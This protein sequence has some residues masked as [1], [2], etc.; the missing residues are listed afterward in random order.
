MNE[1]D[2]LLQKIS[3]YS[4]A[5]KEWN[6]YLDTHPTDREGL[7]MHKRMADKAKELIAKYEEKYG[8]LTTMSSADENCFD[9]IAEPW[10][11]DNQ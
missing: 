11:W 5:E 3:A 2:A 9:W 8:P 1:R 4:F 6:L 10:P 7:A